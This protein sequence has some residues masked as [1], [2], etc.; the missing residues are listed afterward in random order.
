MT[1]ELIPPLLLFHHNN[2]LQDF[3]PKGEPRGATFFFLTV[4][5][6]KELIRS[7]AH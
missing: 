6:I 3:N 5:K 4:K 7:D 2:R 1:V